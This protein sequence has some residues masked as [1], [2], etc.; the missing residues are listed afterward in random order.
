[1]KRPSRGNASAA[2]MRPRI[3]QAALPDRERRF[4]F[5][6]RSSSGERN[7]TPKAD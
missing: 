3:I 1:M 4:W 6:H 7:R 5:R 2:E